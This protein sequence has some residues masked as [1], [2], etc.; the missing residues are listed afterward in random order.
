MLM[1]LIELC[2]LSLLL[3]QEP[4]PV[5]GPANGSAAGTNTSRAVVKLR[6]ENHNSANVITAE[7]APGQDPRKLL[8]QAED[9]LQDRDGGTLSQLA[10]GEDKNIA[11]RAA[12][13][14]GK[15][16]SEEDKS[17]LVQ[18]ALKSPHA[19]ARLQALESIRQTAVVTATPI[20]IHALDD[21]DRRV[22]TIAVQ[23]LDKLRRPTSIEPL[24]GLLSNSPTPEGGLPST[25]VAA[26]LLTL[27]DLN[28]T[29][30]LLRMATAINAGNDHEVGQALTYA[31]QTLSPK[32]DRTEETTVLVA[33]LDHPELMLRRYAITRLTELNSP[34]ALHALEGRL[35]REERELRPLI[36]V[37]I[38]QIRHDSA[39]PPRDELERAQ[40]NA[41]H[42]VAQVKGWWASLDPVRKGL[43]AFSPLFLLIMGW[44]LRRILK[45]RA[46]NEDAITAAEL[47]QPSDDYLESHYEEYEEDYTDSDYEEEY[48][49]EGDS[50]GDMPTNNATA[51]HED[52][53]EECE[54]L[55]FET[56]DWTDP[57]SDAVPADEASTEEG[58]FK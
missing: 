23:I 9:S 35:A 6:V 16:Q 10:F 29:P 3:P 11:A 1:G 25:D 2:L 41:R 5:Q 39:Q 12:W 58:F 46:H 51:N 49:E 42:L 27:S 7:D 50:D 56:S 54:P 37:A 40:A 34:N 53:D 8:Q 47:V 19:E 20:A 55:E 15:S 21:A 36:E 38:G 45:Q 33:V 44:M 57:N 52:L 24:L 17:L 14:L 4:K 22:R 31:F 43:V 26:A 48:A 18:I 13:L 32:L 30:H 28:A